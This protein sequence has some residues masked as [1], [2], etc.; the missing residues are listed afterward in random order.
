[1]PEVCVS[2]SQAADFLI[3]E[4]LMVQGIEEQCFTASLLILRPASSP[5]GGTSKCLSGRH[6]WRAADEPEKEEKP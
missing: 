2:I 4:G 6:S 3:Q 5:G 1:M